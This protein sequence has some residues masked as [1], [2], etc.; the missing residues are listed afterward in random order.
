MRNLTAKGP[1]TG[2]MATARH[3]LPRTGSQNQA[4]VSTEQGPAN[5]VRDSVGHGAEVGRRS[6]CG[7]YLSTRS[8]SKPPQS[9]LPAVQKLF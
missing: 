1:E 2:V 8:P 3:T 9:P 5:H 7:I 4:F 6:L